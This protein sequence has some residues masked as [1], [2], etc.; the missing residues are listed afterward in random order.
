MSYT[1]IYEGKEISLAPREFEVLYLLA[2]RP[3]LIIP[4][5]NIYC[6]VWGVIIMMIR[7][8]INSGTLSMEDTKKDG[9]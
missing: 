9:A 6:S 3:N 7:F 4:K 1:V 5:K 8:L 2:Q